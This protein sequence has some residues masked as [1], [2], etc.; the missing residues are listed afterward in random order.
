MSRVLSSSST[1]SW[2]Y[3]FPTI[4]IT[5][6]GAAT[7]G[8]WLGAFHGR[9]GEP[10]PEFMRWLF[11]GVWLFASTYLILFA[12][13]LCRVVLLP[14]ECELE[15]SR[16]GCASV[17]IP[18]SAVE[19]VAQGLSKPSTITLHLSAPSELGRRVVFLPS[20][21]L[22]SDALTFE[23]ALTTELRALVGRARPS[24]ARST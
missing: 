9:H 5:G 10:A 4:W 14:G 21:Q 11:L 15:V 22:H 17:V 6:F 16:L 13:R 19:R 1:F 8:L 20:G 7:L 23:H 24:A 12:R 18:L 2:R 3:I